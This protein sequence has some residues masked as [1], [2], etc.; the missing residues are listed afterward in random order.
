M[1]CSDIIVII[2]DATNTYIV[3]DVFHMV[4]D[5]INMYFRYIDI[6]EAVGRFSRDGSNIS[7]SD[8]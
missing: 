5:P 8:I 3:T 7:L 1:K 2:A 6:G 4:S